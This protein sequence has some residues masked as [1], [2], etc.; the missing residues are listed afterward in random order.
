MIFGLWCT[1][2][3]KNNQPYSSNRNSFKKSQQKKRPG[4][5]VW[6]FYS[7]L[8]WHFASLWVESRLL[9][10]YNLDTL[11][12]YLSHIH[13]VIPHFKFLRIEFKFCWCASQIHALKFQK[14]YQIGGGFEILVELCH[15][16]YIGRTQPHS[17][18]FVDACFWCD[19]VQLYHCCTIVLPFAPFVAPLVYHIVCMF[20]RPIVPPDVLWVMLTTP[21]RKTNHLWQTV[22]PFF[23]VQPHVVCWEWFNSRS[24]SIELEIWK[25]KA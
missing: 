14:W 15:C 12:T 23:L 25:L 8:P 16:L 1:A 20:V 10:G 6:S 3:K 11:E 24:R 17:F 18:I 9:A 2:P 5:N 22:F 4:C 19:G 7:F 21:Q 13:W